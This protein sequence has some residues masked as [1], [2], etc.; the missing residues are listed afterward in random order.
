MTGTEHRI[1]LAM[2][3][4]FF[5]LLAASAS[6]LVVRHGLGGTTTVWLVMCGVT[7][8]AYAAGVAGWEAF[9]RRGRLAWLAVVVLFWLVL[10]IAA[11]SFAWCAIPLFFLALRLLT[12]RAAVV[13]VVVLT[14]AVIFAEIYLADRLDPSLVL[15]PVAVAAMAAV[16][17][18]ELQRLIDELV[19]TRGELAATQRSAG[20]LEERER[21]SREIHDTLAQGLTSMGILLQAA[22]R[23][24]D[25]APDDARRHL[26]DAAEV[27]A[28]NLDE[29]RHFVRALAP[30]GLSAGSLPRAL[31]DLVGAESRAAGP[32]VRFRVEGEEHPLDVDVQTALLRVAQ[33]AVANARD[34]AH[35]STVMVTLTYLGDAVSLDVADDGSGFDPSRTASAPGRG[36]GIPAMRDRIAGVGGVLTVE[37]APG[38]GTVVAAAVPRAGTPRAE[39]PRAAAPQ[40]ETGQDGA[41]RGEG[42]T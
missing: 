32:R 38:A 39:G 26:R 18:L 33:G 11:P 4:G 29:A 31:A 28:A 15:A 30:P 3:A 2:H 10:V 6:R 8:V 23:Q 20:V 40:D 5:L 25:T 7:A 1:H 9:G 24:W 36:Y 22:D 16:I 21:L 37:S 34:H 12:P 19:R 42:R 14:G 27:A 13:T 41:R 35:A 17:F